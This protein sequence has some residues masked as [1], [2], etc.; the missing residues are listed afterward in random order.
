MVRLHHGEDDRIEVATEAPRNYRKEVALG[1]PALCGAVYTIALMWF[2]ALRLVT[3][4]APLRTA[5]QLRK[6][7]WFEK[8]DVINLRCI[9]S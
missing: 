5:C 7:R 6:E 2:G 8:F 1:K 3:E 4:L 9:G